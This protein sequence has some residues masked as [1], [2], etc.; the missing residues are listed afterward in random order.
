IERLKPYRSL[1]VPMFF[2]PMG[3]LK[4]RRDVI[5]KVKVTK[6]HVEALKAALYHTVF[7]AKDIMEK[8][9]IRERRYFIVR[10]LLNYFVGRVLNKAE[11]VIAK[12]KDF[13][14]KELI[15][16]RPKDEYE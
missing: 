6:E 4:G 15:I 5:A 3:G 8:F 2:V 10:A 11:D 9:Y 13:Q 1:I 14:Y 7:W 12:L 16:E